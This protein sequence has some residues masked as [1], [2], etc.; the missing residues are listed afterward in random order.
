MHLRFPVA[1]DERRVPFVYYFLLVYDYHKVIDFWP[2]PKSADELMLPMPDR[3][4]GV[5]EN[6]KNVAYI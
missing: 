6:R 2:I 1:D 4:K 5:I 3:N